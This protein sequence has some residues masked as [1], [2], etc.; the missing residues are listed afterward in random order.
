MR[1]HPNTARR[2]CI[3]SPDVNRVDRNTP[4]A[5]RF[6]PHF[7]KSLVAILAGNALYFLLLSPRLP[8]LAQHAAGRLDL[9]LVIDFWLCLAC[10]GVLQSL[11]RL[12]KK[13]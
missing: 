10:F 12:H 1:A 2:R 3:T 13:E 8:A 4:S 11:V 5:F 7:W 9:G 6:W